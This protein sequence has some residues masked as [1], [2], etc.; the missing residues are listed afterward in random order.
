MTSW[1]TGYRLLAARLSA[2]DMDI[3][4]VQD[5]LKGVGRPMLH[6]GYLAFEHPEKKTPMRFEVPVPDDFLHVLDVLRGQ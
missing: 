6:A 3:E 4:S 1:E 2:G 5:A